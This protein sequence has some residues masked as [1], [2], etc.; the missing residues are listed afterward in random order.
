MTKQVHLLEHRYERPAG[1][2]Q[3]KLIGVYSSEMLARSA[4]DRTKPLPG[5]CEWPDK[6]VVRAIPVDED[7]F[8]SPARK[9]D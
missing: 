8:P 1:Y 7:L 3:Y 4:L 2:E 6:F 9:Q 5:F